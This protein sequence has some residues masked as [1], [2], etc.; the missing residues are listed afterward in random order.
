[1]EEGKGKARGKRRER[2][3][4]SEREEKGKNEGIRKREGGETKVEKCESGEEIKL[5]ATLDT[6]EE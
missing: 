6:S 4:G 2:E 1:M 5:V 3:E